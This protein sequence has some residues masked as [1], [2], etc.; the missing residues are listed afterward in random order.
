MVDEAQLPAW[1]VD[2]EAYDRLRSRFADVKA[3]STREAR[4]SGVWLPWFEHAPAGDC[5][6]IGHI[7]MRRW[8]AGESGRVVVYLD[9]GN[10]GV[11]FSVWRGTS[12]YAALTSVPLGTKACLVFTSQSN[13]PDFT[14]LSGE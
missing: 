8:A 3:V 9:T 7:V 5:S 10:A 13:E 6:F 1:I 12:S 4:H 2:P 11:Y 14:I